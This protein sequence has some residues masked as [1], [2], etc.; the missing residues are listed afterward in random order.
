MSCAGAVISSLADHATEKRCIANEYFFKTGKGSY[1]EGDV[2]MGVRMP[3]IRAVAA[4]FSDLPYAEISLLLEHEIHE[5]RLCGLIVLVIN[6]KAKPSER[7]RIVDFYL[8]HKH[9]VN[10][11][12]LVDCSAHYV[13]GQAI[14][15]GIKPASLLDELA[16]SEVMWDRRIAMVANWILIRNGDTK[17]PLRL[18]KKLLGDSEDLMHKAVGWILRE[19]WKVDSNAVENFLK[20]HYVQVPRTT[21]RYAIERMEEPKRKQFLRGEF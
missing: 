18:A 4:Q 16:A 11:W 9:R 19:A 20:K 21:L 13:L 14:L 15:D 8:A 17:T 7:K 6:A 10:N 12:D 3:Q 1:S 5:V 2:F